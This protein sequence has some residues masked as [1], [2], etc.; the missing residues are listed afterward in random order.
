MKIF[1]MKNQRNYIRKMIRRH[2]RTNENEMVQNFQ[3]SVFP[4]KALPV[5]THALFHDGAAGSFADSRC[6]IPVTAAFFH[7]K[8]L[9]IYLYTITP[10]FAAIVGPSDQR[11]EPSRAKT[12]K[13]VGKSR[14]EK[15]R[16]AGS[17]AS[18]TWRCRANPGA[19]SSGKS[20]KIPG[21]PRSACRIVCFGMRARRARPPACGARKIDDALVSAALFED[22][23]LAWRSVVVFRAVRGFR[24]LFQG[25]FWAAC[26]LTRA[27]GRVTCP[28]CVGYFWWQS[29]VVWLLI[30]VYF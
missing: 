26:T 24:V 1:F 13:S 25:W 16:S 27:G 2:I 28:G 6:L 22:F 12:G 19:L 29:R 30:V 5:C 21:K 20:R 11:A 17:S 9:N 4:A 10:A 23:A 7:P 14:R 15:L 8:T 18:A 3:C